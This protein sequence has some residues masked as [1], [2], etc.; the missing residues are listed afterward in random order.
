MFS[1]L[2]KHPR[3]LALSAV[4]HL[5]LITAIFLNLNFSDSK[6]Q[7]KQ[8]ELA[9]TVKAKIVDAQQL[10]AQINK[11]KKA[12]E[13]KRKR[14]IEKLK[15]EK[16]AKKRTQEK[17]RKLALEKKKAEDVKRAAEAK[18][19]ADQK[20]KRLAE[21][22]KKKQAEQLK[23][24]QEA[25]KQ[26][27]LAEEKR[28]REEQ[29]ARE[30]EAKRLEQEKREQAAEKRRLAEQELKRRQQELN[31]KLR[32][33]ESQRRLN[34]LREKYIQAIRQVIERNWRQPLEGGEMPDCKV[35]VIQGPGGIILDVSIV[36]CEGGTRTYQLS[37]VNAV[38]KSDP[39]PMPGD[40]SLFDRELF[41]V[42]SPR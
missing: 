6:N 36:A 20:K 12:L 10:E 28:K 2:L 14:E 39:L 1:E 27:K 5:V 7:V 4:F 26:K 18:K 31:E 23:K 9:K 35:R 40:A 24:A 11:N 42:V 21:A 30:A 17:K 16:E 37:I 41:I 13:A 19:Q 33:E 8:A 32:A 38:L 29:I 15:R 22:Q 3:A 25:E 34:S